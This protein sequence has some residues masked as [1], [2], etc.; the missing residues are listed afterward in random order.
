MR[1]LVI[2]F[3]LAASACSA[4]Q[5]TEPELETKRHEQGMDHTEKHGH[6][7]HKAHHGAHD[8]H[9]HAFD[10]PAKYAESWNS[11]ERDAW[12]RPDEVI[13]VMAIE[14]GARVADLGTG[15]GYFVPHLSKAVGPSGKVLA[16]DVEESMVKW[17]VDAAAEQGLGNVEAQKI[18]YDSTAQEPGSLDRILTVNTWHHF[19]D[20]V[21]YSAHLKSVLKPDGMLVVVDFT[22]D[23][24]SGPPPEMRLAPEVV[25]SE[26][27]AGGLVAEVVP[28]ELE[29]QYVIVAKHP[30][31]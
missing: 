29:R 3:A 11:P 12:Q 2:A 18:P 1:N 14:P 15:T 8:G 7:G 22:K 31:P 17:V 13:R 20:R 24:P 23:A 9:H 28:T 6:E 25:I 16:L 30:A 5:S 26:L 21:A 27:E 19:S 4:P 10:D